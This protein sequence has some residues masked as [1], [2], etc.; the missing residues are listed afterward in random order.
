MG[1]DQLEK[2]RQDCILKMVE[3][4]S[5]F[6]RIE[7]S[8]KDDINQKFDLIR[9]YVNGRTPFSYKLNKAL[10]LGSLVEY[11]EKLS[12]DKGLILSLRKM[13]R[14]RNTIAHEKFLVISESKD[15]E[16]INQTMQWLNELHESLIAWYIAHSTD[17]IKTMTK[18][19]ADHND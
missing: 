3:V 10:P 12:D 5:T 19:L 4:L 9:Q 17:R 13:G 1:E 8:V 16:E 6:Q 18:S 7:K 11:L 14:D 2:A 15:L